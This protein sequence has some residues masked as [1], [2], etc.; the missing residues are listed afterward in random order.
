MAINPR[1]FPVIFKT[2]RRAQTKKFPYALIFS[3]EADGL[4]IV[5]CFHSKR[6]PKHWQRRV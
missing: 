3:M 6:D 2:L 1:Q 4:L 5:A